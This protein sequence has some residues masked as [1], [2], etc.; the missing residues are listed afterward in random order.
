LACT[1]ALPTVSWAQDGDAA[2]GGGGNETE[3]ATGERSGSGE[4]EGATS[5]EAEGVTS[6]EAGQS[7]DA[8]AAAF[9]AGEE[10]EP[11][12]EAPVEEQGTGWE[13][14]PDQRFWMVGARWRMIM[15]PNW[16]LD[17]F[18]DFPSEGGGPPFVINHGVGAEFTTRK[19]RFSI[20]GAVWW[21]GYSTDGAFVA[22]EAGDPSDP[23]FVNSDMQLLLFT[24]DFVH[25]Y[26]F[27]HWF[28]ITYGAGLG[29]G[30]K[31]SGDVVRREAS[32]QGNR[33]VECEAPGRPSS[34]DCEA[35]PDGW[36]G[37]ADDRIWPVYPWINLLLGLRFKAFR[38]LEINI[39]GG[40][41]LGFLFGARVNYI[42]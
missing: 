18:M 34:S 23:E 37:E 35:Q 22:T 4:A 19:N 25:S 17:A 24:A 12:I 26:M 31:V 39:D 29:L 30:V 8:D 16:L 10:E 42:F 13:E 5:T 41:G 38:H 21:A 14:P 6:T 27:T 7:L 36:Y 9:L 32:V 1:L 15:V 20:T 33:V 3:E 28:G 11:E 2:N 40:V